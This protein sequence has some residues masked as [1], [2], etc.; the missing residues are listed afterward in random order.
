[1]GG[2]FS[3]KLKGNRDS[4]DDYELLENYEKFEGK[5]NT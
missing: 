1:M 4:P 3:K 2:T 5:A